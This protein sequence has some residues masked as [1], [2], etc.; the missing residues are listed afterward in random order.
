MNK[1]TK[2]NYIEYLSL[3]LVLSYFLIKSIV[4]VILGI[5]LAIY[6][7]NK[8]LIDNF[9]KI[10]KDK[11][12]IKDNIK[13]NNDPDSEIKSVKQKSKKIDS[14]LSLVDIIE[15]SGFI[16]SIEKDESSNAA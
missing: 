2:I 5:S 16:P 10:N 11:I 7:I 15:E 13:V 3:A 8:R 6:I 12:S 1:N 14:L 4:I 9:I